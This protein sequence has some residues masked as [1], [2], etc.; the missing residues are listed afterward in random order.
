MDENI[1]CLFR[2]IY[3]KII[4]LKT[5]SIFNYTYELEK[6]IVSV[7]HEGNYDYVICRYESSAYPIINTKNNIKSKI[8]ID[9][10]DVITDTL[11]KTETKYINGF[12]V[13]SKN[14]DKYI[15]L[16]YHKKCMELFS[17]IF[18]S[19][20]DRSISSRA[21]QSVG[22][23]VV[24]NICPKLV[25]PSHYN[26][27][28][29]DNINRLL[30]VGSL[31][32]LPNFLGICWFI[33]EV[34]PN[35]KRK[36]PDLRLLV[37]GRNPPDELRN[38]IEK[39]SPDIELHSNVPNMTVFYESCGVTVVPLLAGG[40]TRIKVLES[41]IAYRPVISTG[42]GVYGLG[43]ADSKEVL[44]FEDSDSFSEKYQVLRENSKL[45]YE[46]TNNLVNH[47]NTNYVYE[48]FK[49]SMDIV[50]EQYVHRTKI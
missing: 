28:G 24:P 13:I 20:T 6:K 44:I 17:V 12:G 27:K 22:T 36:Y 26:F 41:G 23:Y 32:Y 11:F 19:E 21:E 37:V 49:T 18:C 43:M 48:K 5:W 35:A 16:K 9:V 29:F 50:L 30:F 15:N 31:A 42:I 40:G 47:V 10:D 2:R 14:V 45:Y 25:L 1:E 8:V 4:L 33:T 7:I 34:Y 46:L 39:H 38:L 3:N